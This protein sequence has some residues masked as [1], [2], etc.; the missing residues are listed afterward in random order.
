M[1]M[2]DT[3]AVLFSSPFPPVAHGRVH[4]PAFTKYMSQWQEENIPLQTARQP[5]WSQPAL[6]FE[7]SSCSAKIPCRTMLTRPTS[8]VTTDT[9]GFLPEGSCTSP[10]L[11]WL[12]GDKSTWER[13]KKKHEQKKPTNIIMP[14]SPKCLQFSNFHSTT[15]LEHFNRF[16][17]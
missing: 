7:G 12:R 8:A 15:A 9:L 6:E 17:F 1:L 2:H 14:N 11:S 3:W 13:K 10:G 4:P 16:H 5:E